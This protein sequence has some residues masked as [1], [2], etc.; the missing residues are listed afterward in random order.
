MGLI[1]IEVGLG[2][3]LN[4]ANV[5]RKNFTPCIDFVEIVGL[6]KCKLKNKQ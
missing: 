5:V 4:L 3:N 2:V 6:N 1:A